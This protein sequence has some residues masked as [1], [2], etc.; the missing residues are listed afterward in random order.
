MDDLAT[1][2]LLSA[3]G[4]LIAAIAFYNRDKPEWQLGMRQIL[5]IAIGQVVLG[6]VVWIIVNT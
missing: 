2:L 1:P 6:A 5:V 3:S 4:V